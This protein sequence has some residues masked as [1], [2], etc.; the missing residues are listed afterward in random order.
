MP[1]NR[2]RHWSELQMTDRAWRMSKPR[3][4]DIKE[5]MET[6]LCRLDPRNARNGVDVTILAGDA[7]VAAFVAAEGGRA[8]AERCGKVEKR[9]ALN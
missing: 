7:P 1:R 9:G 3:A 8:G 5:Q 6:G 4:S 2:R